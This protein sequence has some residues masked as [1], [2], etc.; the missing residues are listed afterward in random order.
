MSL[1]E[2]ARKN[3]QR[4]WGRSFC[5]VI[6]IM[7]LSFFLFIGSVLSLSLSNGAESM[8][9]RLGADVMIVPEG[10]DPHVG[11]ILLAGSPST[12]YLPDYTLNEIENLKN[13]LGIDLISPQTFL[14]TLRASCCSY[15]IQILGIDYDS[16]FIIGSWLEESIYH[17]LRDDEII[18]G[19]HVSGWPGD[20]IKFFNRDLKVA[21]RLEQTGMGFDS[22]VFTNRNT[23]AKLSKEAEKFA[24]KPMRNDGSLTSVIM[25]KLKPGNDAVAVTGEINRRLSSKG[26]Y[27][28]SSK[29]FVNNIG[30][31]LKTVSLIIKSVI[32]FLWLISMI[33][34]VLI[35]ALSLSERKKEF[36]IL[37]TIGATRGK[38]IKLC[39]TE[40]LMISFYGAVAGIIIAN[41]VTA[42]GNSFVS[43]ALHL[44]FLMPNLK[45][46][47]YLVIFSFSASIL[48]GIFAGSFAAFKASRLDIHE[49]MRG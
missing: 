7:L 32:I 39:L 25:L 48:T 4:Q 10:Y 38:L 5:L 24:G 36:G 40:I 34:I 37:R 22:M 17:S 46:L 8:A 43:D 27:A 45:I 49:I 31:S 42:I 15:P 20:V 30:D 33:I 6:V 1:R 13:E 21:G 29:K 14:A 41:V 2:I 18:V 23:I 16:D 47:I 12:F 26:I 9:N 35:F 11:S 28:L 19:Y 3:F 44:P